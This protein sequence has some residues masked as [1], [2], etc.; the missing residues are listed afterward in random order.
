MTFARSVFSTFLPCI[1]IGVGLGL[2]HMSSLPS[3]PWWMCSQECV[4]QLPADSSRMLEYLRIASEKWPFLEADLVKN[5]KNLWSDPKSIYDLF[6][7][8]L[9][10]P[11]SFSPFGHPWWI[12]VASYCKIV[13]VQW[14]SLA[15]TVAISRIGKKYGEPWFVPP[16]FYDSNI[17]PQASSLFLSHSF[18]LF[19]PALARS[20]CGQGSSE[21]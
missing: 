5:M 3:W 6:V 11:S 21:Q 20:L 18:H 13:I 10:L 1:E 9:M 16:R 12:V 8:C 19:W 2:R 17:H 14:L 7:R 4:K 15:G